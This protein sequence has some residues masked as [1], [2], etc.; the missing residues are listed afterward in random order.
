MC[1]NGSRSAAFDEFAQ[2]V[3]FRRGEHAL[4]IQIQFHARQLEQMREQEF[5]LQARRLDALLGEK[6]RA[7]LNGFKNR[8]AMFHLSAGAQTVH[9]EPE[10]IFLPHL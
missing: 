5:G 2:R 8:H 10:I 9:N 4:E 7:L 3:R 1:C 6:F